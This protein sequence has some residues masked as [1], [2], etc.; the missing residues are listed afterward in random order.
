MLK[1]AMSASLLRDVSLGETIRTL[2]K[3]LVSGWKNQGIGM[4]TGSWIESAGPAA[5]PW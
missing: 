2:L 4:A 3:R 1:P 5:A